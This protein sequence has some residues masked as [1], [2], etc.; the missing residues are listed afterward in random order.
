MHGVGHGLF[1]GGPLLL[2]GVHVVCEAFFDDTLDDVVAV[3]VFDHFVE[4]V[5]GPV[6]DGFRE[7]GAEVE[8]EDLI[9]A[10][11]HLAALGVE[12]GV[13]QVFVEHVDDVRDHF[14]SAVF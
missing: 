3:L 1:V 12:T 8:S 4:F 14:L 13:N 6:Q 10:L 7:S 5:A 2:H 9:H 11:H